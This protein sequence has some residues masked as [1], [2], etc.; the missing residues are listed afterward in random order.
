MNLKTIHRKNEKLKTGRKKCFI[1]SEM[2]KSLKK[3]E[4]ELADLESGIIASDDRN[5]YFL[6]A[7]NHRNTFE[8]Q[9]KA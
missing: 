2:L 6:S 7:K 9:G 1:S 4:V 8:L 5:P 3:I